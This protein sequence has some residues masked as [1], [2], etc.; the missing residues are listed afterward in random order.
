MLRDILSA[1]TECSLQVPVC[2]SLCSGGLPAACTLLRLCAAVALHL[3][4]S[5][6]LIAR[7]RAIIH[8]GARTAV[9]S[10]ATKTCIRCCRGGDWVPRA[11]S[12][13]TSYQQE[14]FLCYIYVYTAKKGCICALK[15][16]FMRMCH[17][18]KK[19]HIFLCVFTQMNA[20]RARHSTI[21]L[22]IDDINWIEV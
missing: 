6:F 15:F 12:Q 13:Q 16:S 22:H 7:S 21:F 19:Q 10:R 14:I 1:W 9:H 3:T 4:A 8:C 20:C 11:T 2:A 18:R 17:M 5:M